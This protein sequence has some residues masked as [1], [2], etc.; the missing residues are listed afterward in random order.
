MGFGQRLS[1]SLLFGSSLGRSIAVSWCFLLLAVMLLNAWSLRESWLMNLNTT[2]A[3]AVNLALSQAR[4][5]ED[6][7]LQTEISLR[8]IQRNIQQEALGG[9]DV[10]R[11]DRIM[12]EQRSRL[13]QLDGLYYYDASGKWIAGST[14][15]D[16]A[17]AVNAER[18]SFAYH[19]QNGHS[20]IHIGPAIQNPSNDERVIPVSLRLNDAGGGFSGVLLATV[21]VDYFR[22]IYAY[23]ELGGKDILVLMLADS[24]V[25]YARPMPD[26]YI[27]KNLSTSRLF[28]EMLVKSDRGSGEWDSALDGWPRIFGFVRSDRYPLVVAAGYDKTTLRESWLKSKLNDVAVNA[29]L[30]LIILVVGFHMLRQVRINVI[31][32]RELAHLHEELTSINH[33]LQAMAMIDGLTGLPNRRHFDVFLRDSLKRS[34]RSGKPVSLVMMDIDFFKRYND[35]YGHVAGDLCLESVSEALRGMPLRGTDLTARYG[36]EEFAIIM[37]DTL[38]EEAFCVAVRAVE[39]IRKRHLFHGGTDIPDLIVT[40]SAG[41]G[42]LIATGSDTDA[43]RLKERADAALY[44]AKSRGRNQAVL[45]AEA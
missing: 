5:A 37:P 4:Q 43:K 16:P 11:L 25:L 45:Y 33:T 15:R 20:N 24:T 30:M 14:P 8:E 6:T 3:S 40:L 27:G 31:N 9:M 17:G 38:P 13:P 10:A 39:T 19:R 28:R 12:Q 42:S 41:C 44:K 36:G 29:G 32:Q 18:E 7:F 22:Q 35:A 1:S 26:S 34:S 23:Y 2:Q 21:R